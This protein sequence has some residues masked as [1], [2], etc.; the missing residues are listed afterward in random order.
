MN[1]ILSR[2]SNQPN[3]T[4]GRLELFNDDGHRL[5]SFFTL[6]LPYK[7]NVRQVSFIP[8]GVYVVSPFISKKFGNCLKILNVP[9]RSGILFHSGNFIH[10]TKGC[11]LVGKHY[12]INSFGISANVYSSRLAM[13]LLLSQTTANFTLTIKKANYATP[14]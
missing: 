12:T 5:S 11:I 4:L 8:L 14:Y 6:E 13:R 3:F 2:F 9:N 10:E 7:A 1:A